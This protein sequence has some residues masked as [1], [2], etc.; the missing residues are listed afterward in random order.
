MTG[1]LGA[2]P[3]NPNQGGDGCDEQN[4]YFCP[5]GILHRE[6]AG[7]SWAI[8]NTSNSSGVEWKQ[9]K[10]AKNNIEESIREGLFRQRSCLPDR[11]TEHRRI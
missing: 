6:G 5:R 11:A 10:Q 3:P 8:N 9:T 2:S 1:A 7:R 4:D